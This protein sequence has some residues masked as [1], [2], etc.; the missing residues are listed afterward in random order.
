MEDNN[1]ILDNSLNFYS[2]LIVSGLILTFSVYYL[3]LSNNTNQLQNIEA[4]TNE[5]I[6]VIFN[7]NAVNVINAN[8]EDFTDSEFDTQI[9]S[10]NESTGFNDIER[11]FEEIDLKELDLF[12]MPN[13]D[14][15]VCSIY[16]L[17]HFEISSLHSQ[18]MLDYGITE[19]EL[20]EIIDYFSED[21]LLTNQINELII[22]YMFYYH[23]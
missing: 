10:D 1:L 21:E 4:L 16:E 20:I 14:L 5:E 12:F 19:G 3:I 9:A 2:I 23:M 17:K 15:D 11:N 7:E 13:V 6:E 18:E 8:I 22:I